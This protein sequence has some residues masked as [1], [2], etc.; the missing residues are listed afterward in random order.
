L[1]VVFYSLLPPKEY[2]PK[3]C[4][5]LDV[6]LFSLLQA[7]LMIMLVAFKFCI[8]FLNLGLFTFSPLSSSPSSQSGT[9]TRKESFRANQ[10]FDL[11]VI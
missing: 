4:V 1:D 7:T 6:V 3:I 10:N 2:M 11:A 9:A 8:S 5:Y